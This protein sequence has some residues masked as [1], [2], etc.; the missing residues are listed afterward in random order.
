MRTRTART[1]ASL[2]VLALGCGL[3]GCTSVGGDY[4]P[5]MLTLH[6][7]DVDYRNMRGLTL[8][9]NNRMLWSDWHRFIL[10]DRPSRLSPVG[11]SH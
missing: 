3:G 2:F 1:A 6:Q 11:T 5:E 7:R 10:L 9:T 4:S 8:D